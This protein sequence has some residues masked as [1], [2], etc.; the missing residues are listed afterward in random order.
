MSRNLTD[1]LSKLFIKLG[2]KLS[3][4]KENKGPVDYIDDI[5][6]IV[7]PGGGGD[8][9]IYILEYEFGFDEEDQPVYSVND[10]FDNLVNAYKSGKIVLGKNTR[11]PIPEESIDKDFVFVK[12][13][14]SREDGEEVINA[15]KIP[16]TGFSVSNNTLTVFDTEITMYSDNSLE[17][18][19]ET[20]RSN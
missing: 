20:Y 5:T 9:D 19:D 1:A 7:E 8:S 4:S 14:I 18:R 15:V 2:G 16:N 17:L 10:T 12:F 11:A 3:D 6:S 13:N